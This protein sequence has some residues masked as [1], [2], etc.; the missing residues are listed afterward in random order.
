VRDEAIRLEARRN[1]LRARLDRAAEPPPLLHLKMA[2]LYRQ[3]VTQLARGLER[4][5][6]RT[7]AAE[8]LRGLI[9]VIV[10]TPDRETLRI[11]LQGNLAAMLKAARAQ[12]RAHPCRR[13]ESGLLRI[14]S[15][16]STESR[17]RP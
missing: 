10:L 5:E 17:G 11:E 8:A 13:L 7:Q 4:E 9:D 15:G 1:E 3:K 6:S 14:V 12:E 16:L 2:D